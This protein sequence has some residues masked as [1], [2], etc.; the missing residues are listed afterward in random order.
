MRENKT[1]ISLSGIGPAAALRM[2]KGIA[3]A[4]GYTKDTHDVWAV[5][6]FQSVTL[7]GDGKDAA[8]LERTSI[9]VE[10]FYKSL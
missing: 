7:K 9:R 2:I 10:V 1:E 5:P 8:D 3:L 4:R 6:H